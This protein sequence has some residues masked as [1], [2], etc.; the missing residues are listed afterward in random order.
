MHTLVSAAALAAAA[1][2]SPDTAPATHPPATEAGTSQPEPATATVPASGTGAAAPTADGAQ[3]IVLWTPLRETTVVVRGQADRR[4]GATGSVTSVRAE[5]EP[6][7]I[8]DLPAVLPGVWLIND[9]DPGTNILSIRAA[10]TD[11]LQQASVA[12]I[13]DGVP[14]GDTE[15]FT[16]PIF[17]LRSVA[18]LRGPQGALF[19]KNAAGGAIILRTS[20][21]LDPTQ[22]TEAPDYLTATV[23]DGGLRRAEFGVDMGPG[24]DQSYQGLA[25]RLAG[26]YSAHDGWIRNRTLNKEVDGQELAAARL[27]GSWRGEGLFELPT[28]VDARLNW[29]EERGGAAW[30]SSNN[31]TGLA[32]GRLDGAVLTD[33]IGDYEGRAWRNW[34]QGSIQGTIDCNHC[35]G[36]FRFLIARDIYAKRWREELDYRPGPLTFFGL[37]LFPDGLQPI[38]QPIDLDVRTFEMSYLWDSPTIDG[39]SATLGVFR[40][41]VDRRRVDEFGPLLFGA[42]APAYRTQSTQ[43][44]LFG[45]LRLDVDNWLGGEWQFEAQARQ[46]QDERSQTITRSTDG[47]LTDYREGTFSR[48]QPRVAVGYMAQLEGAGFLRVRASWAEAFRPGGFNPTPGAGSIWQPVYAPEITSSTEAGLRFGTGM[49]TG[50]DPVAYWSI[51]LMADVSIFSNQVENYQ[52]YTFIDGQSVTLSVPEVAVDGFELQLGGQVSLDGSAWHGGWDIDLMLSF[53]SYNARLGRFVATDPLLGSPATRDYSGRQ[54]PNAPRT[55]GQFA[56]E[57]TYD[58]DPRRSLGWTW[59]AGLTVHQVG[60]TVYELDNVLYSPER[61]WLDASL[62]ANGGRGGDGDWTLVLSARNITDER[63]AVSAFGQGMVGLL[64]GLGPGGPFDTFTINRGRQVSLT[65]RLAY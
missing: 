10:T 45:G 37:P 32:G 34:V 11:R 15:F 40:Q 50:Y 54:V 55:T 31:V 1:V 14:L 21:G 17:D 4:M 22:F 29:M 57:V 19:G 41:E 23:G 53:M 26:L 48:F 64:A 52:N 35:D 43:M 18:V 44:A 51:D 42:P 9:Q 6:I 28:R 3:T 27:T 16:G 62:S 13:V 33:P 12:M 36:T 65:L 49:D 46:E 63:W 61:T 5:A 2:G 24:Y 58:P 20:T 39:L 30:A 7:T 47:Q 25:V 38:S 8:D 59:T 56:I 60:R